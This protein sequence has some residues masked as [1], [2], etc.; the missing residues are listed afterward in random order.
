MPLENRLIPLIRE[1]IEVVKMIFFKKLNSS[2]TDKYP[3]H[4]ARFC[5]ML[6]GA[7]TN[8]LFGTVNPG[9]PFA[10][11]LRE[12]RRLITSELQNLAVSHEEMRIPLTDALRMQA[13]CDR[14]ENIEDPGS[15][16]L[17][18]DLGI[19]IP[20]RELPLP[21]SFME[22]V[23]RMGKSL[24]LIIPPLPEEHAGQAPGKD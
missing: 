8:E 12:N 2:L 11:F 22:L 21:H 20:E 7:V 15:L 24:G 23:R 10:S 1:G 18:K 6:T 16:A 4:D 14:M 3:E 17:L 5:A 9:E 13:L 19:L